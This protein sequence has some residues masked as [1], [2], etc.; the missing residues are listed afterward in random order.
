LA[1][2]K[3]SEPFRTFLAYLCGSTWTLNQ[4]AVNALP[5]GFV[6]QTM[7]ELGFLPTMWHG[8]WRH[9]PG[10]VGRYSDALAAPLAGRVRVATAVERVERAPAG[11]TVYCGGRGEEFDHVVFALPPQRA[12]ELIADPD[13]V[14]REVPG[15]FESQPNTVYFTSD[16]E[17]A[18]SWTTARR[19]LFAASDVSDPKE[20][21]GR[22]FLFQAGC[23]DL[24]ELCQYAL[25]RPLYMW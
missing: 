1:S 3:Y 14:E 25:E 8:E 6:T 13:D 19:A 22:E 24:T 17:A 2:E 5:F 7:W 9:I 12:L 15:A 18:R 21:A 10:A 23:A 11:G 20:E 16:E 4:P